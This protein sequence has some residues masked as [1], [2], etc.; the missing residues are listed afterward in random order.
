MHDTE[1]TDPAKLVRT[2]RAAAQRRR[3]AGEYSD[4]VRRRINSELPL[5][6]RPE[7]LD[8]LAVIAPGAPLRSNIPVVGRVGKRI[9]S[10]LLAWYLVPMAAQQTEFNLSVLRELRILK[11]AV[12]HGVDQQRSAPSTD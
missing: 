12:G 7:P 4:E 3:V 2:V 9:L 5:E 11:A 8:R 6:Q 10:R 1:P